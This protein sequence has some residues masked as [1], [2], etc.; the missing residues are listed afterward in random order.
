[1]KNIFENLLLQRDK[2]KYNNYKILKELLLFISKN[3]K[4]IIEDSKFVTIL[5]IYLSEN[6]KELKSEDFI[7]DLTIF[8]MELISHYEEGKFDRFNFLLEES[9]VSVPLKK[10]LKEN[11]ELISNILKYHYRDLLLENREEIAFNNYFSITKISKERSDE[12]FVPSVN[13][14]DLNIRILLRGKLFYKNGIFLK[15]GEYLITDYKFQLKEYKVLSDD[16]LMILITLKKDFIEKFQ[17]KELE[18][19]IQ[20]TSS[21]PNNQL[22]KILNKSIFKNNFL[23]FLDT[24]IL[25]LK[26]S[27]LIPDDILSYSEI[28]YKKELDICSLVNIIDENITLPENDIRDILMEKFSITEKNLDEFMYQTYKTTLKKYIGRLK[29]KYILQD[30]MI[31]PNAHLDF[32]LEKYN[33]SN[34]KNFK[35][36]LKTFFNLSIKDFEKSL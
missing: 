3:N 23:F 18:K 19:V 22:R 8:L 1:M 2:K 30:Y 32:L 20:M 33:Y 6:K 7:D 15:D 35:Y 27:N 34:I 25:I 31:F 21:L 12:F 11:K 36:N 16:F 26:N 14:E 5:N 29:I 9:N 13:L 4:F 28:F 17:V 24:I 10:W